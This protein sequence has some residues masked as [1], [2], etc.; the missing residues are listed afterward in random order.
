MLNNKY[1]VIAGCGR[2]GSYLADQLSRNGN[3]V[4]IID[5]NDAAFSNLSPDFSGFR[6]EGDTTRMAVL[7]DAKLKLAD[8]LISVTHDDNINLMVA[9]IARKLFNVPQILAR[10]FDSKKGEVYADSGI[11]IISPAAIAAQM[12]LN[13]VEA[14]VK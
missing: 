6:L 11:K 4:V 5:V 3:S 12:F 10:V 2:L 1:V 9:Q 8:I 7:N 14:P 13:A